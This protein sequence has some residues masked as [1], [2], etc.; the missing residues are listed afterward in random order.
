M[1]LFKNLVTRGLRSAQPAATAVP[2]GTLYYVTDEAVT[3]RSSGTVWQ[4]MSDGVANDA[5]T[6]AKMQNI[7]AASKLLG[8]GDSGAGDPQEITLGTGLTMTGTTLAAAGGGGSSGLVLLE[9]HS[10]SASAALNF[11]TR[12][13]SGQSG[14]IF[15]SDFD[16][17]LIKFIGMRPANSSAALQLQMSTDGGATYVAGTSYNWGYKLD[18]SSLNLWIPDTASDAIYVTSGVGSGAT[19][20]AH[21]SI[22]LTDPLSTTDHKSVIFQSTSLDADLASSGSLNNVQGS[23]R[24]VSLTA[25][26]ACRVKFDTGNITSGIVRIYGIAKT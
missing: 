7:S 20:R 13:A 12:N 8:R 16:D 22:E 4:T 5:I 25:V 18:N 15:Q 6:Y 24:L 3:E 21:G 17:Y 19:N 2:E 10:A 23:G 26:N 11:V 1:S 9:S 14:A